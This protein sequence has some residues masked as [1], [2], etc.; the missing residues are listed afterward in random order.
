[1]TATLKGPRTRARALGVLFSLCLSIFLFHAARLA[2]QEYLATLS[3]TVTDATGALVKDAA[4]KVT[5]T[6]TSVVTTGTTNDDGAYSVPFLVPGNYSVEVTIQGFKPATQ[7]GIVLHA[8]DKARVDFQLE[9][10]STT[11]GVTVKATGQLLTP[12]TASISQ[13]LDAA[14]VADLPNI[15]RNPFIDGD[16][17]AGAYS[18]AYMDRAASQFTQPFSGVASQMVINGISDLH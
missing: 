3:G 18:N 1:M 10:G 17:S 8:S 7:T 4:V 6:D 11:Q 13:T 16:L 14:Q 9:I 15:G 5:N 2:A 12:G